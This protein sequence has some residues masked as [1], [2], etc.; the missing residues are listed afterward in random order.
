MPNDFIDTDGT[1]ASDVK[2]FSKT[3]KILRNP[4][5]QKFLKNKP[6]IRKNVERAAEILIDEPK[7][8]AAMKESIRGILNDRID[9]FFF[10]LVY[11]L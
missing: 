9:V 10:Q 2:V 4:K 1:I 3:N 11:L 8:L 7:P 5:I 6:Q